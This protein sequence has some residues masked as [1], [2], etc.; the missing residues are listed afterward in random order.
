MVSAF[1]FT[2]AVAVAMSWPELLAVGV[3]PPVPYPLPFKI[4]TDFYAFIIRKG[5]SPFVSQVFVL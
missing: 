2:V 4:L 1:P 5:P 3:V